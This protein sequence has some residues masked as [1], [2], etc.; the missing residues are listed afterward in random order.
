[1]LNR[2]TEKG[3]SQK[4][5]RAACPFQDAELPDKSL[6]TNFPYFRK[7]SFVSILL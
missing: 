3:K 6:N 4:I 1:M 2:F 5:F 7:L